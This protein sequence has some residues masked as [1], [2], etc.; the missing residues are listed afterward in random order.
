MPTLI[1]I[2]PTSPMMIETLP[3]WKAIAAMA[4]NRVIGQNGRIP[5]NIPEELKW[6]RKCTT[7]HTIVMGRK[8]WDSLGKPLPNRLNLVLSRTL[9]SIPGA[10]V[11][12]SL[13]EVEALSPTPNTI[14]IIGGSELYNQALPRCSELLLTV[15]TQ[16]YPGDAFF[17]YLGEEWQLSDIVDKTDRYEIQRWRRLL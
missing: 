14:W 15:L 7:G 10:Q 9:P 3:Q 4:R 11:I 8:T 13:D 17:P 1:A 6:F 16:T 2:V 5:W 12:R